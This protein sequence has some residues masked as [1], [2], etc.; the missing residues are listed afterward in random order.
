MF[1]AAQP[2]SA[3]EA[4]LVGRLTAAGRVTIDA[5]AAKALEGGNSLLPA[6]ATSISGSFERG[7]VIDIVD[8][9][10]TILARG[11]AEY[12]SNAAR[13]II[14]RKSSELEAILGYTPRSALVHRNHMVSL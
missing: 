9:S 8:E 14:G 13:R 1:Q 5:G 11:L 4:W 2:T 7:D 12:D 10:G 3:R 6:G